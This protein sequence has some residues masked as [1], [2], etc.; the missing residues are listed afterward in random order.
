MNLAAMDERFMPKRLKE[1]VSEKSKIEGNL[2][3]IEKDCP[4]ADIDAEKKV[5][6]DRCNVF[7]GYPDLKMMLK[8][9]VKL[10]EDYPNSTVWDVA[11]MTLKRE[12]AALVLRFRSKSDEMLLARQ[13][14][15]EV[16]IKSMQD[17]LD[18]VSKMIDA[19]LSS[20]DCYQQYSQAQIEFLQSQIKK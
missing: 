1:L 8:E 20:P 9:L 12:I 3:E 10:M 17:N 7:G 14:Q 4:Y 19:Y 2:K 13:K 15:Y 6:N 16:G 11:A 18:G 5:I